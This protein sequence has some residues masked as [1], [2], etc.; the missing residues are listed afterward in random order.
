MTERREWRTHV[1]GQCADY[2]DRWELEKDARWWAAR[3]RQSGYHVEI[4]SRPVGEWEAQP[5]AGGEESDERTS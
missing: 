3:L 5:D 2:Y 1:T 4:T